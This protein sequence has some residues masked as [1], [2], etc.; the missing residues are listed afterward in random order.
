MFTLQS[1][2]EFP[3]AKSSPE[4]LPNLR[5]LLDLFDLYEFEEDKRS[6]AEALDLDF[7]EEEDDSASED[8][9][10]MYFSPDSASYPSLGKHCSCF[11]SGSR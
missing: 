9:D 7:R 4:A 5:G 11:S 8:M 10:W 3:D 1:E 6:F 2:E